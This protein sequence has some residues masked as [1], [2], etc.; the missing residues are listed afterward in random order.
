VRILVG[1][2]G[3]VDSACAALELMRS[4]HT[5]E[6]AILK[7]H[8]YSDIDGALR[9]AEA[10]AIP[11]HVIDAT[12]SF[13]NIIKENLADEYLAGRTPNP[14]ILCNEKVKFKGLYDFAVEQG[15]DR[16]ATGHYARIVKCTDRFAVAAASDGRKDQSYMLYRLPQEILSMLL[17]PLSDAEKSEVRALAAD[18]GIPVADKKDSQE[19][20]FLPN[21]GHAEFIEQRRGICPKGDFISPDGAMLGR[22]NGIIRYT[23]GQRKGL[24]IALGERVFV[25]DINPVDNTI[26]LSPTMI[27][28]EEITV[29]SLV[30]SGLE[31]LAEGDEIQFTVR[32]RYSAPR[33]PTRVTM[34]HGGVARLKFDTPVTASPGQSAVLYDGDTVLFGGFIRR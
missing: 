25:T 19:I 13:N 27:G 31:T 2:S 22:H 30:F 17:L 26:T 12:E 8:E 1:I 23:V 34:L 11:L 21:G 28:R 5:V 4:G 6:G 18:A 15:F 9:V 16:I 20:C 14:C 10:L 7:M 32:L 33:I 24:G 3:G 29:D